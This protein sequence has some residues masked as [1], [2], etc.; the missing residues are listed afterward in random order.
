MLRECPDWDRRGGGG[1]GGRGRGRGRGYR[2]RPYKSNGVS[3]VFHF[4]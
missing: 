3:K 1:G 2:F 4:H